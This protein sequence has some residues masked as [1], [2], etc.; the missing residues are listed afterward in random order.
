MNWF[1][2]NNIFDAKPAKAPRGKP[3]DKKQQGAAAPST[4]AR[5]FASA[6]A[7]SPVTRRGKLNKSQQTYETIATRLKR[8]K[9]IQN[10]MSAGLVPPEYGFQFEDEPTPCSHTL[11]YSQERDLREH[12]LSENERKA[13]KSLL[14][15]ATNYVLGYVNS[16]DMLT[17][18][19]A[20]R[21]QVK[22][23]LEH[24]QESEC[25]MCG[26][27]FKDNTRLWM[28]YVIVRQPPRKPSAGDE[29]EPEPPR[30][31]PGSFEFA[32]CDCGNSYHPQL[33][34]H[35]V[36]PSINS[37]H[38]QRLFEAGF[39]YQYVFP[40]QYQ[41]RW[42]TDDSLQ[43]VNQ[44]GPFQIVQELLK[45]HKRPNDHII[46]ITLSTTG[47]VVLKEVNH[48]AKLT[49]YRNIFN[50]PTVSDDVD[51][52]TVSSPSALMAA[53]END[54]FKTIQG[55]VFVEIYG[56]SI[57]E[58]V[59]GVITFP[60]KPV[61]GSYCTACK[62][63]KM[64]YSNPVINCSKCGFTNRYIFNGKY[65]YIYFHPEAVQTHATHGELIRYYDLKLHVKICRERMDEYNK[66]QQEEEE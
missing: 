54:T 51:C 59:T 47:G 22:N 42:V 31:V 15:F 50:K 65:D 21:L 63:N 3:A 43:V 1:R 26:Y 12:F 32:C 2:E 58:F 14:R 61:K 18:G 29:P 35:Q 38:A 16:K 45:K 5:Q 28:L 44:N 48:G 30:N 49:R 10:K 37:L 66:Q 6:A 4:V 64:Y 57:Q 9:N 25:T 41:R 11:D 13:M 24:V 34:S 19:R 7:A 8:G 33:H 60:M 40:L 52:F 27:K 53:L 23:G 62:K 55:T 46:S 39:F 20:A 36:Y 17:F 56:F